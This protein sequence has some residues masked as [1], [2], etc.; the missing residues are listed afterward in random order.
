MAI[1][2]VLLSL[3]AAR[4]RDGRLAAGRV[5]RCWAWR[6]DALLSDHPG[7][8]VLRRGLSAARRAKSRYFLACWRAWSALVELAAGL[9]TSGKST[10]L[11]ILNSYEHFKYWFDAG[12]YLRF[13]DFILLF[14]VLYGV[15]LLWM[16]ERG[17]TPDEYPIFGAA[18][19]L[20]LFSVT[21][22]HPHYTIWLVPFLALTIAGSP[23]MTVY[24]GIQIVCILIY[25]AQ[26][27]SW[28]TWDLLQPLLGSRV[29]SLPDPVEAIQ[30]QIEPRLFF[31][32]FRS[33]LTA[34]SLW[35]AWRL[36]RGLSCATTAAPPGV[37]QAEP[38][39]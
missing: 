3:A 24:H 21:F 39:A 14:P 26:W 27:G 6:V 5:W 36:L 15:A 9:L 11:T 38:G 17:I 2:L 28:T 20:L 31:G 30:S 34:I 1:L 29:A 13:D 35:M 22:F 33:I 18:A 4:K 32:F 16:S 12:L 25:G 8:A 7:R 10:I 19:F 23:R 37:V